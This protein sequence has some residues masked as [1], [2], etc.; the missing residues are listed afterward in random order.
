MDFHINS[1]WLLINTLDILVYPI[2]KHMEYQYR[3]LI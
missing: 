1:N 3:L 2:V